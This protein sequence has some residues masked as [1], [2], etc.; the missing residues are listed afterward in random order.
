MP[1]DHHVAIAFQ[2]VHK[3]WLRPFVQSFGQG[4]SVSFRLLPCRRLPV[5]ENV[6]LTAAGS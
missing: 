5:K 2:T 6:R 1:L 3:S 4:L